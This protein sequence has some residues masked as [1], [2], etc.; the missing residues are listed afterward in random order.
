MQFLVVKLV[1]VIGFG[2]VHFIADDR[3]EVFVCL[4]A[5][6]SELCLGLSI[7][8]ATIV[9]LSNI[10][11]ISVNIGVEIC[12]GLKSSIRIHT[13]VISLVRQ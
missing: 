13:D 4:L 12:Q 2:K 7:F 6:S 3:L 10:K 11:C 5:V 9:N 1:V 8:F